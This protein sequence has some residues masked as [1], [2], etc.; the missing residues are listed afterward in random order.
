MLLGKFGPSK[1]VPLT[2]LQQQLDLCTV[3]VYLS[4]W[5]KVAATF[6][7]L[8]SSGNK[9]QSVNPKIIEEHSCHRRVH[10]QFG[11]CS[12]RGIPC[13][14]TMEGIK[15]KELVSIGDLNTF[16]S[17]SSDQRK[18][19]SYVKL[20]S[21]GYS[22]KMVGH[23]GCSMKLDKSGTSLRCNRCVSTNITGV[24][25]FRVELA[26]DDGDDCATFCGLR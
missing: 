11:R 18:P 7:G 1:G 22:N 8:L 20:W 2:T 10:K 19:I 24:N 3:V 12:S 23:T 13:I 6:R 5:D 4:L 26:D 21:L 16:I 25:R 14:D 15:K 9:T 17:N